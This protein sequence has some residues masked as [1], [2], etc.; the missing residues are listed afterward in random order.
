MVR[1]T[2]APTSLS[3]P[4]ILTRPWRSHSA[5]IWRS[6]A[7]SALRVTLPSRMT[8]ETPGVAV[9]AAAG[10]ATKASTAM[11]GS[12]YFSMSSVLVTTLRSRGAAANTGVPC[13]DDAPRPAAGSSAPSRTRFTRVHALYL[14]RGSHED[15]PRPVGSGSQHTRM[16]Q[17]RAMAAERQTAIRPEP[18]RRGRIVESARAELSSGVP[19]RA[20]PPRQKLL[21]SRCQ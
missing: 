6:D 3:A 10:D 15:L 17:R 18:D 7:C 8:S 19:K 14:T 2:G 5:R 20:E 13:F 16:T 1:V 4:T 21:P 11:A 12:V 9:C